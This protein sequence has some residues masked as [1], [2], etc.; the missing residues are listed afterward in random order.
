M[1][2]RNALILFCAVLLLLVVLALMWNGLI[3][4]R[5][6]P[7]MVNVQ[8][9]PTPAAVEGEGVEPLTETDYLAVFMEGKKIGHSVHTRTV[10]AGKVT[11]SEQVSITISRIGIPVTITMTETS[12][13]T[14]D[15][16]PLRFESVQSLASMTT[17]KTVGVVREDGT[18]DVV[19]TQ[20]GADQKSTI[21]WPQGALM[22]E[23]LRLLTLEKGLKPGVEYSA[24]IFSPEVMQGLTAK[25]SIK[26]KKEVD[27]LGRV[28]KLTEVV[29]AMTMPGA[30]NVVT[31][32]YVDDE[33]RTLKSVVP[34]A[35]MVIEMVDCPKEFALGKNDVLDL[36]DRM[37][38]KSPE[39]IEDVHS[40]AAITYTLNPG[41]AADF[42]IPTTDNQKATRTPEG[43]VVLEVRP[44]AA[45]AGGEFPYQGNDPAL[46]EATQPTRFLQCDNE[47][48]V[49]LAREAVGDA[50]DAAQAAGRI[51]AFVARYIDNKSLSVGY[52]SAAE[53]VESR[54][55]DCSEF[56]VLTAALCRAVGI[57]S[58]VVVGV[59]YVQ[60]WGGRQGFGGHA[61]TQAWIGGK[62][63]G[64]DAAFKSGGRGG[65]DAGHIALAV[66][67]GEPGDFFNM[68]TALGQFQI[69]KVEAE[70]VP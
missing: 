59:A 65:Y 55:G 45:P 47:K 23:G 54:Q 37:F 7:A 62:W 36:I 10:E 16:K 51:E 50:K 3:A 67:N 61:W 43:K 66:G 34:M 1:K 52:A 60:E 14:P 58:Q 28:V 25:V 49:A 13:E 12:V 70:R 64:L 9:A 39:P 44:V 35:G 24:S 4:R 53:V 29:T 19:A 68:A 57:P 46:R 32:S 42:T 31:T 48:I 40:V 2:R 27:L 63:V 17:M 22:S 56:A 11:T 30:G 33:M 6:E 18:V 15:G 21:Q 5:P 41:P 20:A 69:E 26:D 8:E 38:V